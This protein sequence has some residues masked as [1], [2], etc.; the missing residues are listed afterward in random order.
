MALS[1]AASNDDEIDQLDVIDAILES[2]MEEEIYIELPKGFVLGKLGKIE[3]TDN[4][5]PRVIV[6]L[7]KS[8]YGLWQSALNWY[9]VLHKISYCTRMCGMNG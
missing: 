6:R 7:Q 9:T 1:T 8:L 2:A 5:R 4:N 3:I